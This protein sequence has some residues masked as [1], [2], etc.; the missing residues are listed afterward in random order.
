MQLRL[1]LELELELDPGKLGGGWN[2]QQRP[3]NIITNS[4]TEINVQ[5]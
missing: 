1:E 5:V 3:D 2:V 4:C